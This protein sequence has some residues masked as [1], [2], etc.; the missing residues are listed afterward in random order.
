[1]EG[2]SREAWAVD[3]PHRATSDSTAL[4]LPFQQRDTRSTDGIGTRSGLTRR[5]PRRKRWMRTVSDPR[6]VG[7]IWPVALPLF[8][9]PSN[10]APAPPP[11]LRGR[12]FW[13]A[14]RCVSPGG[15]AALPRPLPSFLPSTLRN[16][17]ARSVSSVVVTPSPTERPP[18]VNTSPQRRVSMRK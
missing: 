5:E 18:A 12:A 11:L 8:A 3:D 15:R 10:P 14:E 1:M 17:S 7:R 6:R 9:P 13:H 4:G 16:A 2:I